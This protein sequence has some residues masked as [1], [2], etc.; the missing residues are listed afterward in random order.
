[1]KLYLSVINLQRNYHLELRTMCRTSTAYLRTEKPH[2]L[3]PSMAAEKC[4]MSAKFKIYAH[5]NGQTMRANSRN[6]A[7]NLIDCVL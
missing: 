3:L 6:K 7:S 4:L 5:G 2:T 1:M